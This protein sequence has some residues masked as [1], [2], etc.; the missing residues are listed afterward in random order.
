MNSEVEISVLMPAYNA[1]TTILPAIWSVLNQSF[2]NFELLIYLDGCTDKTAETIAGLKDSRI[3]IFNEEKNNGIVF[4]RNY[5]VSKA[6]GK[7]IAWL[8]ADD[9]MLPERLSSQ[10][11]YL[12]VHPD[13][14]LLGT[15]CEVRNDNAIKTVKWP[16]ESNWLSAWLFF[17]N[18]FVQSSVMLRNNGKKIEFNPEF[19]YL[20]DYYF[21]CNNLALSKFTIYPKILCSYYQPNQQARIDKYKQH[22][23]VAKREKILA[24]NMAKLDVDL[25]KNE[26]ALFR[27]FLS[28]N[29]RIKLGD[30]N[31][32]FSIFKQLIVANNR[33][34]FISKKE[35]NAIVAYQMLRLMRNAGYGYLPAWKYVVFHIIASL[36]GY[37]HAPKLKKKH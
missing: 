34:E 18:P 6:T 24:Q 37:L 8:D 31:I 27:E 35:F 25:G 29:M 20:E 33:R 7:Y 14:D 17:R 30:C 2:E 22:D 12:Q 21:Y 10:F 9:Y 5:L 13:I 11:N 26:L 3:K 1:Q 36:R 4:S 16:V 28:S 23:F 19:E 32:L 15:W